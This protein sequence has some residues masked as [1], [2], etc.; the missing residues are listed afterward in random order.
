MNWRLQA[1]ITEPTSTVRVPLDKARTDPEVSEELDECRRLRVFIIL[2]M[3]YM[4]GLFVWSLIT[5][6]VLASQ[7]PHHGTTEDGAK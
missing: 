6:T 5:V 4:S 1:G 7:H 3:Y 2:E